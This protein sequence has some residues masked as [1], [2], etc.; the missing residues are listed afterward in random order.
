MQVKHKAL[1]R[2]ARLLNSVS[3]RDKVRIILFKH[4]II[5]VFRVER[6]LVGVG[7]GRWWIERK[8]LE[9]IFCLPP[10]GIYK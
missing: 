4:Y 7:W 5:I 8:G 3:L 1:D 6:I 2:L 10:H 9:Y